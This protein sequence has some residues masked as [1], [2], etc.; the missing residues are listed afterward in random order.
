MPVV[1]LDSI[2]AV[3]DARERAA[4]RRE[5]GSGL[6]TQ[7]LEVESHGLISGSS[8]SRGSGRGLRCGIRHAKATFSQR[9]QPR[10]GRHERS[11]PGDHQRGSRAERVHEQAAGADRGELCG[12]ARGVVGGECAAVDGVGRAR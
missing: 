6:F 12:V 9:G 11:E 4:N 3:P 8:G 1:A 5:G 10:S 7:S 2:D